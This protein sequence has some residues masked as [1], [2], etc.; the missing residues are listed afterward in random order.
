MEL[1]EEGQSSYVIFPPSTILTL[2]SILSTSTTTTTTA[3]SSPSLSITALSLGSRKR[4]MLTTTE[5]GPLNLSAKKSRQLSSSLTPHITFVHRLQLSLFSY[6]PT[7]STASSFS[8]SVSNDPLL[9]SLLSAPSP[10]PLSVANQ[11]L[12]FSSNPITQ[13]RTPLCPTSPFNRHNK[14]YPR[15]S[16]FPTPLHR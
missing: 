15:P 1:V 16:H 9:S 12:S 11:S 3:R 6:Q 4:K 14:F 8:G 10:Q 5:E 2:A 13:Y 7:E